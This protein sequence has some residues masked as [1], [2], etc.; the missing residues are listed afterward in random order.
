M[1]RIALILSVVFIL[2]ISCNE[3]SE[4][5]SDFFREGSL[6][7]V[8][9]DTLSLRVSTTILD[10]II[11][12]N[13]NRL[14]VGHHI[15]EDL[16]D[17][18]AAAFF[19]VEP[20]AS[21]ET[22]SNV[23]NLDN[24]STDYLR[25][26]LTLFY[27][28][29]SYYDTLN[30]QTLYVYELED[31]IEPEDNGYLYNTSKTKIKDTP[32]GQRTFRAKPN[33]GD[34]VEISLL[35]SFGL[36]IYNKAIVDDERLS[37]SEDF[38][39]EILKGI[40]VLPDAANSS[41]ILGFNT[42]A[43]LRIYYTDRTEVPS[44]EKYLRFFV[45]TRYNQLRANRSTTSLNSLTSGEESLISSLTNNKAYAQ[46]GTPLNIR[47]EIPY[48]KSIL[49]D[50]D[51]LIIT[52]A[53]LTFRPVEDSYENNTPLPSQF[54]LYGVN[55]NNEVYGNFLN[56]VAGS[57]YANLY[58]DTYLGRDTYYKADVVDFIL[59]QIAIEEFND[60]ALLLSLPNTEIQ[61]TVNRLY[62][63]DQQSDFDMELK[64][65]FARIR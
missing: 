24:I 21:T 15:D 35:D 13:T 34:S 53:D 29:Y 54:I 63:G 11:T 60:N 4:I 16:G 61:S 7:I 5:G 42:N 45:S 62:V 14:L 44:E 48:L 57:G 59:S 41:A 27:D 26:S 22:G 2:S 51:A 56:E 40:A 12:S 18:Y 38:V 3:T 36:S 39:E 20:R 1:K 64:V 49:I 52:Q 25:T 46:G 8:Y 30:N 55:K 37:V 9:T 17:I 10:S 32:L 33:S 23:Y 19:Q 47:I 28:S 31:E 58:E 50:N 43:E 6:D 65:Y